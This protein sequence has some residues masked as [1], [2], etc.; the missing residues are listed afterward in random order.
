MSDWTLKKGRFRPVP[1]PVVLAVMDGVGLGPDDEGNAVK[2]ARTP[3]LDALFARHDCLPIAAHGTAVGLP[4]DDD[5]GNSE[6]GHNAMGAGRI[7]DQ[8]AS[9]VNQ[10]LESGALFE[11]ETWRWLVDGVKESGEPLHF[12]GLLSDGNV[13]SHEAHLHAMLRRAAQQGVRKVRVHVLLDGRDVGETT[14]LVYVDRLEQVLAEITDAEHDYRVASGGGRMHITMDRY[15]ADWAMVQR[16][17]DTHVHG[18]G[19]MFGGAREAI[20]TLR[21][22]HPGVTDQFLPAF[23]IADGHGPVGTIRDGASVVFFNFRGDRAI[24]ITRAFEQDDF[25]AFDRQPRPAV[26][27]AG[28]MLYDGDLKLPT[29]YLVAPPA[30]D[31]TLGEYLARNG[32]T[33]FACS[34]TQ[35]YGHVT[36]FWNGNRS[37]AFDRQLEVYCEIPSDSVPFEQRPW[38]K[39]AEIVDATLAALRTGNVRHARINFA[40]GDMVGH[41]G[42]LRPTIM[43]VEAVDLALERLLAGVEALGGVVLVTADHGNAE[44]MFEHQKGKQD[45]VRDAQGRLKPKTSHTLNPVPLCLYDPH[46]HLPKLG[47]TVER[48]GLANLAATLL[49]MLGFEPPEDYERSLFP[50]DDA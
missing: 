19:R 37:G 11:S 12:I 17:W 45:F 4:S 6:V 49:E 43:A 14:A 22:Q 28:M 5:M 2:L 21:E 10:A 46:G 24:E 30:I 1:G 16:G 47:R 36:Y 40:N 39:A 48:P 50:R 26:R 41:T 35:K 18:K 44:E 20:E 27:Y 9:R 38:M 7:Y 29:R 3:T 15:E 33:Q 25:T 13:H 34:E 8:G 32:I 31:R 42:K 23:V